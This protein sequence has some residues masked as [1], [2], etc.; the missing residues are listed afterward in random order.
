MGEDGEETAGRNLPVAESESFN[1]PTG[2][3]IGYCR[4]LV[5]RNGGIVGPRSIKPPMASAAA[6]LAQFR[7]VVAVVAGFCHGQFL[8][9]FHGEKSSQIQASFHKMSE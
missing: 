8:L 1:L 7:Q 5:Q 3:I 6:G 9:D 2:G 4:R